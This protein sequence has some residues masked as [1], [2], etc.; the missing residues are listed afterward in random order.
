ML[1]APASSAVR[2]ISSTCSGASLIPG[3][4][5]AIRMPA[6]TPASFS[7]R[8]ASSRARGDGV[9]GS[10]SRHAPSSIVGTDR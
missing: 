10:V 8:T 5:G 1:I 2:T 4:N 7:F 3:I 6:G 9:C